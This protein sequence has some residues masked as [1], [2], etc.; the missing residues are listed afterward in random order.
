[1]L[2]IDHLLTRESSEGNLLFH[3][4]CADT[5]KLILG[6]G[7][8][9]LSTLDGMNDPRERTEWFADD[10]VMPE[11]DVTLESLKKHDEV[12]GQVD[13][14][15]RQAARITCLTLDRERFKA[16]DQDVFFHRGWGRARMWEQYANQHK[17]A[18]LVFD[19][20]ELCY[21]MDDGRKTEHGEV[22]S[23]SPVTY[24]DRRLKI[25]MQGVY[26]S[27]EAIAEAVD[28]LSTSGKAIGDL[29]YVKNTDW[30]SESE[31]RILVMYGEQAAL[32]NLGK[33]LFIA[34]LSS[35]R[36]IVLGEK[37]VDVDWLLGAAAQR[38]LIR[39]DVTRCSWDNGAP[40]LGTY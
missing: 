8:L 30:A 38:G 40:V 21:A 2:S 28:N 23:T 20:N 9:R 5:L 25:P 10:L 19:L 7:S 18:V 16:S 13:V 36:A 6:G 24:Q 4:T 14:L 26:D 27:I 3:Y 17:G 35:L 37:W 15:L 34:Y 29:F 32:A 1:M 39:S 31:F 12:V 33:P 11:G 22:F